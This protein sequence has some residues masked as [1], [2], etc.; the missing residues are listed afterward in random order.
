MLDERVVLNVESKWI[1]DV[2]AR[3]SRDVPGT[4]V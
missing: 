1:A 4:V 3:F 2:A